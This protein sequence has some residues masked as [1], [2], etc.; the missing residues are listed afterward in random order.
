MNLICR[1]KWMDGWMNESIH[2]KANWMQT[3]CFIY[4][5]HATNQLNQYLQFIRNS[6]FQHES[7]SYMQNEKNCNWARFTQYIYIYIHTHF[8][9][10]W[11][12]YFTRGK[13]HNFN[14]RQ[15]KI[16]SCAR[17]YRLIWNVQFI[18][19]SEIFACKMCKYYLLNRL[20]ISKIFEIYSKYLFQTFPLAHLNMYV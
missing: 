11:L 16:F 7:H 15:F 5:I 1:D 17:Y 19:D 6:L 14:L 18:Q 2:W 13:Y 20:R 10:R 8:G 12:L 3:N 4:L 9:I